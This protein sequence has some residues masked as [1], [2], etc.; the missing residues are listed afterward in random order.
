MIIY[1]SGY[2]DTETSVLAMANTTVTKVEP[3]HRKVRAHSTVVLLILLLG[4]APML[5]TSISSRRIYTSPPDWACLPTGRIAFPFDKANHAGD[6][7]KASSILSI[8]L[9]FGRFGFGAAKWIDV[10][11]DV[12]VGHCGQVLLAYLAYIVF[13]KAMMFSMES[14]PIDHD[15]FVGLAFKP[16]SAETMWTAASGLIREKLHHVGDARRR[17]HRHT[18]IMSALLPCGIYILVFPVMVSAMTGYQAVSTSWVTRPDTGDLINMTS[19]SQEQLTLTNGTRIGLQEAFRIPS[20]SEYEN[21]FTQYML[22]Y[23]IKPGNA[24]NYT[25]ND[26][27][28]VDHNV[29]SQVVVN[30]EMKQLPPPLLSFIIVNTNPEYVAGGVTFNATWIHDHS[31]CEPSDEYRWGFSFLFLFIFCVLTAVFVA[32]MCAVWWTVYW[33]SRFDR[34]DQ[35]FNTYSAVM[36]LASNVAADLGDDGADLTAKELKGEIRRRRCT[37]KLNTSD[38]PISRQEEDVAIRQGSIDTK[39]LPG[40]R[41]VIGYFFTQKDVDRAKS[42]LPQWR[43]RAIAKMKRSVVN[44]GTELQ[45]KSGPYLRIPEQHVEQATVAQDTETLNERRDPHGPESA[46]SPALAKASGEWDEEQFAH[47]QAGSGNDEES[48]DDRGGEEESIVREDNHSLHSE[49]VLLTPQAP[50]H[51][52]DTETTRRQGFERVATPT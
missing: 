45:M 30:G 39:L 20:P 21:D 12:V 35:G 3:F 50:Q 52:A 24:S 33:H 36:D 34:T 28:G 15:L 42:V 4:I 18:W 5:A 29:S 47:S 26:P 10:L 23:G 8:N 27:I 48:A 14:H 13:A 9:G 44:E 16:F 1:R 7:W 2:F 17:I 43:R 46:A 41:G 6:L 49:R 31:T 51:A 11:W 32:L 40:N 19:L 25:A 38:L 22:D 37:V